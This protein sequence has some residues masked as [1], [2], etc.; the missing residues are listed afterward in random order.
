MKKNIPQ[1]TNELEM[2]MLPISERTL[3]FGNELMLA[4]NFNLHRAITIKC[5]KG[6]FFIKRCD[7]SAHFHSKRNIFAK[8]QNKYP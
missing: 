7:V 2:M 4:D 3:T 1:Q 8:I 6:L 5:S